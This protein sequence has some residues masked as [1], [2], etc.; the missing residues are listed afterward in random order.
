LADAACV[1]VVRLLV[2]S[3]ARAYDR[4]MSRQVSVHLLPEHFEP[5]A[6]RGSV[7]VVIDVLRASTTIVHAIQAGAASVVPFGEVD[8]ALEFAAGQP[9]GTVVL[10]GERGGARIDCFDLDNSPLSYTP[11]IVRG[12]TVAFTTTNGTRALLR[13]REA[14]RILIGAFVNLSAIGKALRADKRPVHLVCAGTDR[15][16][17]SEDV[18][19]AGAIAAGIQR[20]TGAVLPPDD[21]TE[22]ATREYESLGP[23]QQSLVAVLRESAGG[24]N[25]IELGSEADIEQ[26]ARVDLFDLVP[27][28]QPLSGRIV[29]SATIW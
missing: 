6:L 25:L 29:D 18:L 7:A 27:E 5:E 1:G 9:K 15:R 2:A 3:P 8:E 11:E 12:K 13:C 16:V 4:R 24:R 28:Y 14:E 26:A 10:G 20:I 23:G 21:L 22:M 17:T 19:C